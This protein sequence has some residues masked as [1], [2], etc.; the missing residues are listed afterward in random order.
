VPHL[1]AALREARRVLLPRARL[2]ASVPVDGTKDAAWL[3]LDEVVDRWLGPR[4]EAVDQKPTRDVVADLERFEQAALDAGFGSAGVELI[5]EKVRW[6]SAGEFVSQFAGWWFCASRME[7]IDDDRREKFID[8]AT[9]TLRR[10]YPGAFQTTG[11]N[12]VLLATAS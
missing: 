4:P 11:R 10:E 2:A 5:E 1:S 6:P 9:S 3:L 7:G 8:E 12:H